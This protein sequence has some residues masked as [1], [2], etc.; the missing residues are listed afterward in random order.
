[1]EDV[2]KFMCSKKVKEL[3]KVYENKR[4]FRKPTFVETNLD[5]EEIKMETNDYLIKR[6]L[7]RICNYWNRDERSRKYI[8]H[9]MA[10]F[11]PENAKEP[12]DSFTNDELE[13][14]LNFCS[15]SG[16]KMA[17]NSDVELSY[18]AYNACR[19]IVCEEAK[20]KKLKKLGFKEVDTLRKM[21]EAMPIEIRNINIGYR[22]VCS[23][24]ILSYNSIVALTIFA[25]DCFDVE[26]Q[27]VVGFTRFCLSNEKAEQIEVLKNQ[28]NNTETEH[29]I[30]IENFLKDEDLKKLASIR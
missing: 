3:E 11:L 27:E 4:T 6:S 5:Q 15:L 26:E 9:L 21:K 17:S 7:T 12:V 23:R 8:K 1:M 24:K 13:R 10:S 16:C 30:G 20:E 28:D 2:E 14:G 25:S 22:S 19:K 29:L 18:G